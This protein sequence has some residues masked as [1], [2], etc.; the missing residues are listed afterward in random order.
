MESGSVSRDQEIVTGVEAAKAVGIAPNTLLKWMKDPGFDA[1]YREA[2]RLAF[3][4]VDHSRHSLSQHFGDG[5]DLAGGDLMKTVVKRITRLEDRFATQRDFVGN[6]RDRL[7][8]VVARMDRALSLETSR[9]KRSL[10]ASGSLMEVV[11]LDG[12]RGGL[13]D[14]DLEKFVQRFPI[15]RI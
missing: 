5:N 3:S 12:V 8:I 10:T 4:H 13:S 2:R 15:E 7:R 9:C 6:P 1:A 14:E 11:K